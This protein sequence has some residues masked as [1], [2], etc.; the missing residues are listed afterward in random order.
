MAP[1]SF[2][3]SRLSSM[4]SIF[5]QKAETDG[6][7]LMADYDLDGIRDLVFIKTANTGTGT[8]E[9]HIATSVYETSRGGAA[10]L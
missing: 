3:A 1:R 8:V 9:V 2:R 6:T 7:W 4:T 10:A 5:Q